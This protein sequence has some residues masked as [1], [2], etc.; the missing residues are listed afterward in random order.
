MMTNNTKARHLEILAVAANEVEKAGGVE[1]I[2]ALPWQER[3][4]TLGKMITA[5]IETTGCVRETARRNVAKAMRRARYALM[6]QEAPDSW[7]G[8]RPNQTGRPPS[9]PDEKR[10]AVATM[11]TADA[12]ELAEAIAV[13]LDLPGWGHSLEAGLQALVEGD[14]S[15]REG[16]DDM[17]IIL[18]EIKIE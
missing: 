4:A 14:P 8:Q 15:L 6:Q 2:D 17:G 3:R 16:L 9:P 7:G 18:K 1:S 12:K 11:L 5:V 13:I 10:I